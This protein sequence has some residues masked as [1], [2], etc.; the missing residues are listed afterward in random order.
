MSTVEEVRGVT[1]GA[2]AAL[3]ALVSGSMV[4]SGRMCRCA[5]HAVTWAWDQVSVD[6][7]ATAAAQDRADKAAQAKAAKAKAKIEAWRRKQK[8]AEDEDDAEDE[9]QDEQEEVRAAPVRPVRRPALESLGMFI[10]GGVLVA[11]TGGTLGV[12]V[13]P[14]MQ[15]LAPW[16]GMIATV[17]GLAW[18]AAAW[19]VAPPPAEDDENEDQDEHQDDVEDAEVSPGDLL[20]RHVLGALAA[21]EEEG[22]PGLHVVHLIATAEKAGILAPGA[23]DKAAMRAWLEAS[24][25]PVT[26]S[27]KVRR[28]VDYGVRVDRLTEA[29]GMGPGEALKRVFGGGPAAPAERAPQAPTEAP[30]EAAAIPAPAPGLTLVKPLPD[31]D[32]PEGAQGAA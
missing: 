16:R 10:L 13:W 26:K 31:G 20:A 14:Y 29:L 17:G 12:L 18:M 25:F 24:G 32:S 1:R 21:L 4:L 19:M 8:G 28:E 15:A 9:H 7:E 6:A 11:G 22:R 27:V 23:M 30:V 3:T 2:G 5:A